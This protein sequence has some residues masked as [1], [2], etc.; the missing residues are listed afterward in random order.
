[1]A[2]SNRICSIPDCGK[3]HRARG[4]CFMHYQR[5]RD[6]GDPLAGRVPNGEALKFYSEVVL[7]HDGLDCLIWPFNMNPNGYGSMDVN[8]KK[9]IVSR[10]LCEDVNGPPPTPEHEAA[11]SCGKGHLGCV[12][13]GHLAWKTSKENKADMLTHGTINRG[14]RN[15]QSKL[16]EDQAR[17][18]LSLK[19]KNTVRE[20]SSQ[21]G[22]S[23]MVVSRIQNGK[24]WAWI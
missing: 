12:T 19:G 9:R 3:P 21:F 10:L 24:S 7:R 16:T 13:K 22:V 18:I 4:F 17:E 8:G 2:N 6:H 11:H 15:G 1:M 20:L 14:T 23:P 5:H